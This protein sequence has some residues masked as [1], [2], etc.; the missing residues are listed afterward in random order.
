MSIDRRIREGLH[1]NADPLDPPVADALGVSRSRGVRK[2]WLRRTA[3]ASLT[4][5]ALSVTTA[6]VVSGLLRPPDP[7]VGS[8][9]PFVGV[10][11]TADQPSSE[12]LDRAIAHGADPACASDFVGDA[13]TLRYTL[14][15]EGDRWVMYRSDDGGTP[16]GVENGFWDSP[17][18]G[19]LRL[20]APNAPATYLFDRSIDGA[21]LQLTVRDLA[22]GGDPDSCFVRAGSQIEFGAPFTRVADSALTA[23]D[24]SLRRMFDS[25]LSSPSQAF[26]LGTSSIDGTWTTGAIDE[27][28]IRDAI[29]SV[30]AARCVGAPLSQVGQHRFEL[31]ID[32]DRWSIVDSSRASRPV[33]SGWVQVWA[34]DGSAAHPNLRLTPLDRPEWILGRVAVDPNVFRVRGIQV[35]DAGSDPRC[36]SIA[37]AAVWFGFP[38]SRVR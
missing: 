25:A 4:V 22:L 32:G 7:L 29:D 18:A 13:G 11:Q 15:V 2:L 19:E 6:I 27:R 36:E 33:G 34:L 38:F 31:T 35:Q 9:D 37:R 26:G 23:P 3:T 10:W 14:V 5:A 20:I 12:A 28:Q 24:P 16:Q 8:S 30:G 1:R 17:Q 21:T